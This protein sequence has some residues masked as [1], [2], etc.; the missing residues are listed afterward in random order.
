MLYYFSKIPDIISCISFKHFN[1]QFY[2]IRIG[3]DSQI[4]CFQEKT[5]LF[6]N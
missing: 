2:V 3:V 6:Y 1:L 5:Q 4:G